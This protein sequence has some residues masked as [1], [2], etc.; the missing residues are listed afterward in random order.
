ME[1]LNY[2]I[3]SRATILLGRESV[4]RIDSAVIELVKNTYDA[5]ASFCLLCFDA[6]HDAI[7]IIDNGTGMTRDTVENCWMLIGTDNKKSDF[8][9]LKG[10]V[11]SGEKGIGRFALDR[12]GSFC[13]MYT[14]NDPNGP[15]IHWQTAWTQ[16]E[17]SGKLLDDMSATI[18]YLPNCYASYLPRSIQDNMQL[19]SKKFMLATFEKGTFFKITGLR[20]KWDEKFRNAIQS[21]LGYLLPP[22]I[23]DDFNIAVM[24]G[25]NSKYELIENDITD[26]YDYKIRAKFDGQSFQITIDRNEFDINRMPAE[27]FKM[28]RF[29]V[30]PYRREDFV[31]RVIHKNLSITELLSNNDLKKI[32]AIKA[33]G[34]FT[35]EYTFMKLQSNEDSR[36]LLFTKE[37]SKMRGKWMKL[38]AGIKVYRDSFWIRPYG[39]I[40]GKYDWLGLDARKSRNPTA[41]T[42]A[43]ESW[44]VRNAQGYGV[45]SISRVYNPS[46]VDMSS[47]EGL[48]ENDTYHELQEVL[49]AIISQFEHDRS[50]IARTLKLYSDSINR[51]ENVK[52]EGQAIAKK[53]LEQSSSSGEGYEEGDQYNQTK[54]LAEA[55]QYYQEEREELV[56][57]ISLLRSLA[58]NGL[59]TSAI[60]HDLKSIQSQLV[61]RVGTFKRAIE[62]DDEMLISRH[63]TDLNNNDDFLKAWISVI[64]TQTRADK[65]KRTKHDL[66]SL[67]VN[68]VSTLNPI[69][70]RKKIKIDIQADNNSFER[71]V[72]PI[73]IESIVYNLIINSME[74]FEGSD[75]EQRCIRIRLSCDDYFDLVYSDNGKGIDSTT[76]SD[77]YD[78]FKFGTTSKVDSN[79]DKIGTGLGMYI[80]SST[81]REYNSSPKLVKWKGCFEMQFSIGK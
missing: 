53:I 69:L 24:S 18:E 6:E 81:L 63:L 71:R 33:I 50:Y 14:Q 44:T 25:I 2:K 15:T 22:S 62:T 46:I 74:A 55:V 72:F 26:E 54:R 51:K 65:R 45:V 75:I 70:A 79:G 41:V 37:I 7:Y 64:T 8:N 52:Q 47:R 68:T 61:N 27:L 39:E 21:S 11:K 67:V 78:I 34:A 73:D 1:K 23:H 77:P 35:F 49:I 10:R 42:H 76:F 48:I 36:E 31:N 66:V 28:E 56:S 30:Y 32:E 38:H 3:S 20:D 57:E 16:F 43:G 13:D 17:E 80:V 40:N 59:I 9:S 29:Q 60:V 58:T 19:I 4:S 12:L 5:D